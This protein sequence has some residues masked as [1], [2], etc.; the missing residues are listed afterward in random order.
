MFKSSAKAL[1]KFIVSTLGIRCVD[2]AGSD[3]RIS[4]RRFTAMTDTIGCVFSAKFKWDGLDK[5]LSSI[6]IIFQVPEDSSR[7]PRGLSLCLR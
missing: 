3:W 4:A 5:L 2:R 6:M 1:K 7:I